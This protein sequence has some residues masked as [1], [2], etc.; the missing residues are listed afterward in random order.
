M[1]KHI[2]ILFSSVN[3]IMNRKV[4][5]LR[6][7]SKCFTSKNMLKFFASFQLDLRKLDNFSLKL[8][9]ITSRIAELFN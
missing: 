9:D 4:Y 3:F 2:C 6:N 1:Q 8:T 7:S 5:C